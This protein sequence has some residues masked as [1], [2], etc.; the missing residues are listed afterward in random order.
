MKKLLF[1]LFFILCTTLLTH[2][3]ESLGFNWQSVIR[4]F[5]QNPLSNTSVDIEFLIKEG[6]GTNAPTLYHERHNGVKSNAFGLVNLVV[7]TGPMW[8]GT[9]ALLTGACQKYIWKSA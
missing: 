8:R 5:E 9:L 2:A 7:G 1:I 3:Q 6:G 4:D